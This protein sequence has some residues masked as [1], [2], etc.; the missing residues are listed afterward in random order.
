MLFNLISLCYK[1]Q[2]WSFLFFLLGEKRKKS[3]REREG[4]L[5]QVRKTD[6]YHLNHSCRIQI[7]HFNKEKMLYQYS[8]VK[9]SEEYWARRL[10]VSN[11]SFYHS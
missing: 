7:P 10:A 6:F 1:S 8:Q 5:K 4:N 2:S 9:I 11:H 3:E